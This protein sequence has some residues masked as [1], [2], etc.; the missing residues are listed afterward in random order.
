MASASLAWSFSQNAQSGS[1]TSFIAAACRESLVVLSNALLTVSR[2]FYCKE[3][4]EVNSVTNCA[5]SGAWG[6]L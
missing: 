4:Q 3:M 5:G 2:S 1:P 6:W